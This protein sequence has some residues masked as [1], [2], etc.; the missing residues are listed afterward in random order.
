MA[1]LVINTILLLRQ[2]PNLVTEIGTPLYGILSFR[3][4]GRKPR[5]YRCRESSVRI[6][7]TRKLTPNFLHLTTNQPTNPPRERPIYIIGFP[8]PP[9]HSLTPSTWAFS[10]YLERPSDRPLRSL[11]FP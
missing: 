2:D 10:S 11:S 8:L 7:G 1:T 4:D 3:S 9:F 6:P 5:K